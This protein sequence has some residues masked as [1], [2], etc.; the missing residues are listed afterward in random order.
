MIASGCSTGSDRDKTPVIRN[1]VIKNALPPEAE[2][3]CPVPTILPDRALG[4]GETVSAWSRDRSNLRIC[5]Q[6][7]A[8]AVAAIKDK[9]EPQ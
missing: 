4:E 6:R 3:P 9:A 8:A 5:E 2:K 1:V 7:R